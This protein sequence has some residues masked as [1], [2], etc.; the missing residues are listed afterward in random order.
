MPI[1]WLSP[2][3]YGHLTGDK[4]FVGTQ[5]YHISTCTLDCRKHNTVK[6]RISFNM[7]N[8]TGTICLIIGILCN[9]KFR[10]FWWFSV[11]HYPS[12][13][14]FAKKL[15]YGV[16][17]WPSAKILCYTILDKAVMMY[18]GPIKVKVCQSLIC[19][20]WCTINSIIGVISA[21]LHTIY[22]TILHS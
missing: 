10:H 15:V 22:S 9:I 13:F 12:I 18:F 14:L 16:R 19:S 11:R 20:R 17:Q 21:E 5:L 1:N 4:I 8:Q 3:I 7:V 6:K 2:I